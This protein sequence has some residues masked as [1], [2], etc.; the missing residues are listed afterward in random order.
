M[1]YNKKEEGVKKIFVSVVLVLALAATLVAEEKAAAAPVITRDGIARAAKAVADKGVYPA[2]SASPRH[3]QPTT[4]RRYEK[5]QRVAYY[6]VLA[7]KIAT[8]YPRGEVT[9]AK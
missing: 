1:P 8:G 5:W 4:V 7:S 9:L 2:S 3:S 6:S